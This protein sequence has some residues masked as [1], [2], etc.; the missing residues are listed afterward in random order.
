MCSCIAVLLILSFIMTLIILQTIV[1]TAKS[2]FSLSKKYY[3]RNTV[4]VWDSNDIWHT[5]TTINGSDTHNA[6]DSHENYYNAG[7]FTIIS[8]GILSILPLSMIFNFCTCGLISKKYD[9]IMFLVLY[10]PSSFTLIAFCYVCTDPC[11]QSVTGP[12]LLGISTGLQMIVPLVLCCVSCILYKFIPL[13]TLII[14]DSDSVIA[15]PPAVNTPFIS[16]A[17]QH[18]ESSEN[19]HPIINHFNPPRQKHTIPMNRSIESTV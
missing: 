19:S 4:L 7:I 8:T 11:V 12:I 18:K 9:V 1:V 15:A 10:V 13:S 14:S 3:Q 5:D 17:A 16:Q 6:C 2:E